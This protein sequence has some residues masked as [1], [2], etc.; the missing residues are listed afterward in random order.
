M[1]PIS[2]QPLNRPLLWAGVLDLAIAAALTASL[3]FGPRAYSFFGVEFLAEMA[4]R[5]SAVPGLISGGLA[6]AGVIAGTYA[7]TT[8]LWGPRLPQARPILVVAAV[9]F[10]IRGAWLAIE[11]GRAIPDYQSVR[12]RELLLSAAAVSIGVLHLVGV[13]Q[14]APPGTPSS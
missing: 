5:G 11:L 10:L 2:G 14:I 4:E 6:L 3:I 1:S 7:L 9:A 12:F 13:R 8:A